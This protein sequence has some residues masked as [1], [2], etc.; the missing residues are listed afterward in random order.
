[1]DKYL[2]GKLDASA[3]HQLEREAQNDPFLMDALEGYE[4]NG[5][6]QQPNLTELQQRLAERIAPPERGRSILLWRV[7]SIA[8]ALL[9]MIGIGYW[10]LIP[11]T[12][13]HKQT[14]ALIKPQQQVEAPVA[15][16]PQN[17]ES[18]SISKNLSIA[19]SIAPGVKNR[20]VPESSNQETM[21]A[22]YKKTDT[23]DNKT[24]A[25]NK[26]EKE[27]GVEVGSDGSLTH[28]GQAL[29]KARINGKD[30]AGGNLAQ[31]IQNLPAEIVEKI[32]VV[33]DYGDQKAK[34]A[35]K[36]AEPT[37]IANTTTTD[38]LVSAPPQINKAPNTLIKK[39]GDSL[40]RALNGKVAGAAIIK[41]E[42]LNKK[43]TGRVVDKDNGEPLPG[44][45]IKLNGNN[46]TAQTDVN[47][48]FTI[49][50]PIA[51]Q[52][53]TAN[54][55]GYQQ[56]EVVVKN[57][58]KLNI[59]LSPSSQSLSE[60]VVVGY[61]TQKKQSITGNVN[62]AS[63]TTE[64]GA[65][66]LIGQKAY[67]NYLQQSSKVTNENIG[68]VNLAFTVDVNGRINNI[69][70]IKSTIPKL[71]QHAIDLI[72]K[73]PAWVGAKNG[74]PEVIKITIKFHR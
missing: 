58:D 18:A 37:K 72:Q 27:Q 36:S 11:K 6:D 71:N 65:H 7:L 28:Q 21:L 34:T 2:K 60:I 48:N 46:N 66:P 19:K 26:G 68:K 24:I 9:L 61:G 62:T 73:G 51:G 67:K 17:K 52:T 39:Q 3:M 10:E 20:E 74:K 49:T 33:D 5:K 70:V 41:P 69:Y 30:Y 63:D 44:V 42:D 50:L 25:Y 4:V 1:M 23:V 13:I 47:G 16:Q 31:A 12:N 22:T 53:L 14:A 8:A 56:Q 57:E 35:S 40:T 54:Y 32:Q 29:T 55:V 38:E 43:I 45:S 59:E 64:K 15:I